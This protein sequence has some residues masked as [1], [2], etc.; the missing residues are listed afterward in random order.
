MLLS[1]FKTSISY[2]VIALSLGSYQPLFA[3][4]VLDRG[5]VISKEAKE[6]DQGWIDSRSS[7]EMTLKNK[8]GDEDKRRI[9]IKT[10]EVIGDGDKT[11][12]TFDQPRDI[13]GTSFLSYSHTLKPDDQWLYLP[14]LKRVKRIASRNK[15]GP[16]MGSEF[17]FEDLSS[18]ELEKFSYKYLG[19]ESCGLGQCYIVEQSPMDKFS[20]YSRRVV[21]IDTDLYRLEKIDFYDRKD[22]LLKT[23]NFFEYKLYQQKYW[24]AHEQ[25]MKNHQSGKETTLSVSEIQFSTGIKKSEF[26]QTA[27]KRA[28]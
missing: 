16:F 10:L 12:T 18:F 14:S 22:S 3:S 4:E 19:Q 20:G 5:F 17:S 26:T 1:K 15:S 11:L 6:R 8:A 13:K 24:R 9:R 27:L 7:L 25:V 28:R 2:V 23:L 21:W